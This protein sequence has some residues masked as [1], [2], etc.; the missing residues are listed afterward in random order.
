MALSYDDFAKIDIRT[1]TIIKVERFPKARKPAY[2]VWVDFGPEIGTLQT[3]AQIT[4]N[5]IPEVLIG[6]Q[7]AGVINLGSKNIAGFESQFLLLGFEDDK[8][9]I[10]LATA[11]SQVPNGKRLH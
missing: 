8:G 4:V 10:V 3:S 2:Q 9:A 7:V 1:G 11:D 5:Y 6:K